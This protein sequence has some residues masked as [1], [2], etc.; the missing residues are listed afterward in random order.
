MFL[1]SSPLL[2]P[3]KQSHLHFLVVDYAVEPRSRIVR[4]E[5][6]FVGGCVAFSALYITNLIFL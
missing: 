2:L 5:I 6:H 1:I 4:S 3:Y